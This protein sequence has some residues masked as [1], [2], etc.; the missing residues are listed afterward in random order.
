M[1]EEIRDQEP[2]ENLSKEERD[3]LNA[4]NTKFIIKKLKKI[5]KKNIKK[6]SKK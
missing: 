1:P 4:V 3:K 2:I 5:S 6:I